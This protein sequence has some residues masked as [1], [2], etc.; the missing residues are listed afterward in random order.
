MRR[1]TATRLAA[2]NQC[3]KNMQLGN[4]TYVPHPL[5]LGD[6]KGNRFSLALR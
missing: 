3:L 2:L 6:L 4:F 1:I 5:K